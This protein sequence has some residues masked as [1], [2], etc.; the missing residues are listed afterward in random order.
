VA[1]R[2]GFPNA[3]RVVGAATTEELGNARAQDPRLTEGHR[4][5]E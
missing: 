4:N 3:S 1:H 2:Q 5:D